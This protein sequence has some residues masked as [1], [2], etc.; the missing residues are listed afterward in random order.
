[1]GGWLGSSDKSL[2]KD[3]ETLTASN[4]AL[5]E[6]INR[7]A[8]RMADAATSEAES[9]YEE[10]LKYLKESMS[11]TQQM[12]KRS[13]ADSSS[14]IFGV[15][16]KASSNHKINKAMT[17]AEWQRI[18]SIVGKNVSTAKEFFNLSSEQMALVANNAADIYNKI[19]KYADDGYKNAAQYMDEY[20]AYY[21]QI[22][23]LQDA[24]NEKLTSTDFDSVR[25]EFKSTLL[26]M[27]SDTEDFAEAF[28]DMMEEA[29][30]ESLMSSKYDALIKSW[31]EEFASAMTD[32]TLTS[33]EQSKLKSSW[34]DLVNQAVNERDALIEAM[35]W[36]SSSSRTGT[37]SSGIAA[38]QESVSELNGRATVIQGHTYSISENMKLLVSLSAAALEKLG[39]I[40][41]NTAQTNDKLDTMNSNM[42]RLR[43]TV[44]DIS[45]RGVRIKT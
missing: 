32:G 6:S 1:M 28:E 34:D 42:K 26:D 12:M 30:V 41:Q 18:S 21:E 5:K 22:E 8:E 24:L 17:K 13:A 15:G 23:E 33:D 39:G 9:I 20:I 7:L 25:D 16:S 14:G 45:T 36:E 3:I 2:E 40:E 43:D 35:G 37:S 44:D 19:K 31:Y 29:V 27:E 10:Q 4:E 38:S 11:N